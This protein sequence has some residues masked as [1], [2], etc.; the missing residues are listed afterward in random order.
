MNKAVILVPTL[1]FPDF[2]QAVPTENLKIYYG[3]V[4]CEQCFHEH[5]LNRNK[6][7]PNDFFKN[8]FEQWQNNAQVRTAWVL[9]IFTYTLFRF[10]RF[11]TVASFTGLCTGYVFS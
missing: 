11:V 4:F 2:C 5:V 8:C 9:R 10:I 3:Q 1:K 6:D 7:S